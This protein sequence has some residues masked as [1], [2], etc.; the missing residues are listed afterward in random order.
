MKVAARIETQG[1]GDESDDS[2]AADRDMPIAGNGAFG[3]AARGLADAAFDVY[4]CLKIARIDGDRGGSDRKECRRFRQREVERDIKRSSQRLRIELVRDMDIIGRRFGDADG[5]EEGCE[6]E[7]RDVRQEIGDIQFAQI[8][9]DQAIEERGGGQGEA[10][11][12]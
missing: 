4:G 12:T 3:G 8:A 7:A 6:I 9:G 2:E 1:G 11:L 5:A 10:E